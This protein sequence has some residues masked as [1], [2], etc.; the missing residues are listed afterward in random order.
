LP[1]FRNCHALPGLGCRRLCEELSD[2]ECGAF[3]VWGDPSLYDSTMRIIGAISPSARHEFEYEVI[4][5]ISSVQALAAK[6]R[7]A[8]N[9]IGRSI[10]ITTPRTLPVKNSYFQPNID[11]LCH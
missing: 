4:P 7:V 9:A 5:G 1:I 2:G 10:K 8:L 3:L 11:S 6:H